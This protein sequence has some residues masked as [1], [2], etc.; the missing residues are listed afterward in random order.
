[1]VG[2]VTGLAQLGKG[3]QGLYPGFQGKSCIRRVFP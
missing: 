1:V 2:F 3:H